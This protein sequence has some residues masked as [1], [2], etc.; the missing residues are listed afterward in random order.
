[1]RMH[2]SD[3]GVLVRE[4]RA[5]RAVPCAGA[6]RQ[7]SV[8]RQPLARA[9]VTSPTWRGRSQSR[10]RPAV[11]QLR[12]Q[13]DR[14]PL[15]GEPGRVRGLHALRAAR[16]SRHSRR[17]AA[18][19]VPQQPGTRRPRRRL[20]QLAR[21]HAG[22]AYAMA[23]NYLLSRMAPRS[24]SCS[25][26]AERD[27]LVPRAGGARRRTA[28]APG[29]GLVRGPLNDLTGQ[30]VWA[31]NQAYLF[32]G[33]DLFGRALERHGHPRAGEA[34]DAARAIREAIDR[35]FGAASMRSPV[36]QLRDGTWAPYVPAEALSPRRLLDQWTP[37]TSTRAP[38][39]SCASRRCPRAA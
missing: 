34:R 29:S 19:P 25:P 5:G 39:T 12:V 6:R 2:A 26:G 13:P 21:L 31:F 27:G 32:A 7:R 18:G 20:R 1:M 35:G 33:L 28:K 36:V 38:C 15:A 17:R 30:G 23:Q 24:R 8:P 4:R 14:H 16:L 9:P 10:H 37:P 11:L 22:D 3:A